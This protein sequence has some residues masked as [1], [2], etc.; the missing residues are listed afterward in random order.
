MKLTGLSFWSMVLVT[1]SASLYFTNKTVQ[2]FDT[3]F[4]KLL[5]GIMAAGF[6]LATYGLIK[7]KGSL[8]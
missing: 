2:I 7:Q 6:G 5:T 3:K 8:S 1:G 4:E